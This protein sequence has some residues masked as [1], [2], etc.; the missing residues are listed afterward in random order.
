MNPKKNT[1][2]TD[3]IKI[4]AAAGAVAGSIGLWS[5]FSNRSIEIAN[6][7]SLDA[8]SSGGIAS[9]S[10]QLVVN[11]PFQPDPT[12]TATTAP[13]LR[14]VNINFDGA[15]AP[16]QPEIQRIVIDTGTAASG[17]SS[18]GGSSNN[19]SAPAPVTNTKTS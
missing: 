7:N 3:A 14:E 5:M 2:S 19:A 6:Q 17:S 16:A 8:Q 9:A 13:A 15:P 4:I 12:A 10:E 1:N 18:G 11:T